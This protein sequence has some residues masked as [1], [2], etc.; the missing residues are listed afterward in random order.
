[1]T[2]YREA[3]LRLLRAEQRRRAPKK[4][5]EAFDPLADCFAQQARFIADDSDQRAVC[6]SRR[7]G[8]TSGF[9]RDAVKRSWENP[10]ASVIYLNETRDRA[11]RTFWEELKTYVQAKGLPYVPNEAKLC[12]RG[13]KNRWIWVSGGETK[14]HVNR[15]KGVLP[16]AA[17]FYTDECQ[18]WDA[19]VLKHAYAEVIAPALAD[20]GGRFT[21]GGVPGWAPDPEDTWFAWTHGGEFSVH[22][23]EE[24]QNPWSMWDNP[25]VKNARQLLERICKT[26]QVGEDDPTIQREFWG[27]WVRDVAILV[28]GALDDDLNAYDPPPPDG[29][30]IF[31]AGVDGGYVDEASI[32]TLG[33]RPVDAARKIYVTRSDVFGH[34]GAY[35]IIDRVKQALEPLGARLI[36]AAADPAAGMK[37]I[38]HD[39]WAKYG[40][41]LE[42]AD[43][44]PDVKVGAAKLLAASLACRETLIP[45]RHRLFRSLRRVQWDPEHRGERIKGHVPDDVDALLYGFRKAWP[46]ICQRPPAPEKTYEEQRLERIIAAQEGGDIDA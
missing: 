1:M 10:G 3:R 45:R 18:D 15:W 30:Y 23:P 33:W 19:E 31:A 29:D 37:N 8:K 20:M 5:S 27:R 21:A 38:A 6:T 4:S 9:V 12:L 26:L 46:W 11:Q 44:A 41:E 32:A 25:N 16:K 13:P 22:G 42:A 35:E 14:K 40:I 7:A 28:F 17:A 24:S 2:P 39:V 43:K 34:R 36:G